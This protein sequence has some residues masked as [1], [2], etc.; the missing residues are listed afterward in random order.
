[1]YVYRTR[2]TYLENAHKIL[3]DGPVIIVEFI[4]SQLQTLVGSNFVNHRPVPEHKL[5]HVVCGVPAYHDIMGDKPFLEIE[6]MA[7]AAPSRE[8]NCG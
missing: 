2:Q 3:D 4:P 6:L 7:D 8:S 5:Q 1:M